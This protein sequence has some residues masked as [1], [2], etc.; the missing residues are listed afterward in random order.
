MTVNSKTKHAPDASLMQRERERE[1][2][3]K[4]AVWIVCTL[5]IIVSCIHIDN[6][7]L[8]KKMRT[9]IHIDNIHPMQNCTVV[10]ILI[11][12]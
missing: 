5:H 3:A 8:V 12:Y 10:Y 4:K 6:V 7:Y 2:V 1:R 9:Y 11:M